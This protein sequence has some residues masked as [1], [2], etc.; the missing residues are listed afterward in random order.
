MVKL[1][2]IFFFFNY[3]R[4]TINVLI[5]V[6]IMCILERERDRQTIRQRKREG[7]LQDK[8]KFTQKEGGLKYNLFAGGRGPTPSI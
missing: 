4:K 7:G 3:K 1:E 5:E 6:H 2:I 8:E